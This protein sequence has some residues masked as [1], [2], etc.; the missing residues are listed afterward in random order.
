MKSINRKNDDERDEYKTAASSSSLSQGGAGE[1]AVCECACVYVSVFFPGG[2][3]A[4]QGR[5]YGGGDE[6]TI[7]KKV[8]HRRIVTRYP[9]VARRRFVFCAYSPS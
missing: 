3:R 8:F 7:G 4:M 5:R 1:A 6:T 2:Q 9:S